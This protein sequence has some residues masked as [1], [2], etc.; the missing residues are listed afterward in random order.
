ML[1]PH[2]LHD[3]LKAI[4]KKRR[5]RD[6]RLTPAQRMARFEALQAAAWKVL[7]SNPA[8]LIAFHQRSRR[9]RRQSEVRSLVSKLRSQ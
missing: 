5:R 9:S 7:T 4:E 3:T 1:P 8:A 6:V 2:N